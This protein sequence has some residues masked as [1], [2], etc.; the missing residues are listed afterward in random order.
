MKADHLVV[1]V[2]PLFLKEDFMFSLASVVSPVLIA[3]IA[4][5]YHKETVII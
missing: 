5:H 4:S 1:N 3:A 2:Q